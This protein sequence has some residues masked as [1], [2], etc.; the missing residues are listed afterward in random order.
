MRPTPNHALH[1]PTKTMKTQIIPMLLA[2]TS[3]TF[4]QTADKDFVGKTMVLKASKDG[5]NGILL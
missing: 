4:A 2:C 5:S 3:L 1:L